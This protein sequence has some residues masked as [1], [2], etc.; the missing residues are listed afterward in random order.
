MANGG[1]SAGG[2]VTRPRCKPLRMSDLLH[3]WEKKSA[4]HQKQYKRW[5]EKADR[6]PKRNRI[7]EKLP[8]KAENK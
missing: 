3:N 8:E 1:P 7:L 2:S 6:A 5:L 4:D